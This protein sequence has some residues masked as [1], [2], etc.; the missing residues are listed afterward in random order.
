MKGDPFSST[1]K[2]KVKVTFLKKFTNKINPGSGMD[3]QPLFTSSR[4]QSSNLPNNNNTIPWKLVA[5]ILLTLWIQKT[6]QCLVIYPMDK[7]IRVQGSTRYKGN[8]VSIPTNTTKF[9]GL[10]HLKFHRNLFLNDT[11]FT[12][13]VIHV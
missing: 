11:K 13:L 8:T 5:A 2:K 7:I 3:N 9:I 10:S 1:M 12:G 4:G 6:E